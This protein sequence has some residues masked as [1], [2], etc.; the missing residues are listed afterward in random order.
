MFGFLGR[1]PEF[2][3]MFSSSPVNIFFSRQPLNKFCIV[4][5]AKRLM[6]HPLTFLSLGL[7]IA[8]NNPKGLHLKKN[9]ILERIYKLTFNIIT[10]LFLNCRRKL[11]IQFGIHRI[12]T[13][14]F[15]SFLISFLTHFSSCSSYFFRYGCFVFVRNL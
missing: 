4:Q 15:Q 12:H 2:W 1:R 10:Y 5:I 6:L 14:L 7:K 13:Y 9:K 11:L 3:M 8:Q